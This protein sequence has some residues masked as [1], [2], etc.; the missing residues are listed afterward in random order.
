MLRSSLGLKISF[1]ANSIAQM[2][3]D[4]LCCLKYKKVFLPK[5]HL[6]VDTNFFM[7]AINVSQREWCHK[8]QYFYFYVEL[9]LWV[10]K[11]KYREKLLLFFWRFIWAVYEQPLETWSLCS[12]QYQNPKSAELFLLKDWWFWKNIHKTVQ[13]IFLSLTPG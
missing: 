9:V 5:S 1:E 12:V 10:L 6:L 11:E 4:I 3:K 13:A 2:V 7:T 8:V